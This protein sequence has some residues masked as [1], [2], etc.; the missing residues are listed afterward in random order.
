MQPSS[1]NGFKFQNSAHTISLFADD[2]ILMLTDVETF[3]ASAHQ[4]LKM[5]NGLSYHKV[6]DT[7]SYIIQ[8]KLAGLYPYTWSVT[9]I[10]YL[11]ITLTPKVEE[12]FKANYL[13]FLD[14]LRPKLQNLAKTELSWSGRLAA[15]KM[16]LLPQFLYL[17]RML[18]IPVPNTFFTINTIYGKVERQGVHSL[19]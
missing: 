12:L 7:K 15:F 10:T 9:G 13:P 4:V 18:P 2:I 1:H 14:R 16:M 3:L 19:D 6:N 5:F 11:G 8:H 17:F